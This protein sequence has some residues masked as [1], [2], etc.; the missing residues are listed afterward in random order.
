MPRSGACGGV[1]GRCGGL[2]GN[3]DLLDW[4]CGELR[5]GVGAT[6]GL[7]A[8]GLASTVGS[9]VRGAIRCPKL[10]FC[11]L[12]SATSRVSTFGK[13]LLALLGCGP[14][15]MIGAMQCIKS[16]SPAPAPPT[17]NPACSQAALIAPQAAWRAAASTEIGA[18]TARIN[19]LS[20]R[21]QT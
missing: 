2:A 18:L 4:D 9:G 15:R 17:T 21:A 19:V 5:W 6:C 16:P 11:T 7:V 1:S 12:Q 10:G 20:M 8:L 13:G 3:G 14:C